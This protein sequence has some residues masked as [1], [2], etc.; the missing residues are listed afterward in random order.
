MCV[1]NSMY[2]TNYLSFASF[3]LLETSLQIV[4][5][6]DAVVQNVMELKRF[7]LYLANICTF[8]R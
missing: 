3:S 1:I 6:S 8:I 4:D 7:L 2:Y 5:V